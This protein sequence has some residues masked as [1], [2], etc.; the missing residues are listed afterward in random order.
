MYWLKS[1]L[2][3]LTIPWTQR[4]LEFGP[5][6]SG[7]NS[8]YSKFAFIQKENRILTSCVSFR[9]LEKNQ[10]GQAFCRKK[11]FETLIYV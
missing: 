11:Y 1:F 9:V 10:V 3:Y 2:H 4:S 8:G 7:Q 5:T 6:L